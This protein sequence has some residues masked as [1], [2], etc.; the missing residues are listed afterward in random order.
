MEYEGLV[1][2]TGASIEG[3]REIATGLGVHLVEQDLK[4]GDEVKVLVRPAAGSRQYRALSTAGA[5]KN[6]LCWHGQHYF[7]AQVFARFPNAEIHTWYNKWNF[8]LFDAGAVAWTRQQ[9]HDKAQTDTCDCTPEMAEEALRSPR[10]IWAKAK[11]PV[12]TVIVFTKDLY[13]PADDHSPAGYY[14]LKNQKGRVLGH[15]CA[16]GHRVRLLNAPDE[17][18]FGAVLGEE[19]V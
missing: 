3:L 13:A 19:F 4:R 10:E 12:G 17:A 18:W 14:A 1:K 16:E 6:S 5:V 11:L 15:N 8:A 2:V 9:I 7:M